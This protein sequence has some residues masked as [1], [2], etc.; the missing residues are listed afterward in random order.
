MR[1]L[2]DTRSGTTG[3]LTLC[4]RGRVDVALHARV[5]MRYDFGL[6]GRRLDLGAE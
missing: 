2:S 1:Q 5:K 6:T 3:P 4:F